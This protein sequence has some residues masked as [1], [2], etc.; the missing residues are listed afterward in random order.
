MTTF[1]PSHAYALIDSALF[2]DTDES[3]LGFGRRLEFVWRS[4]VIY[5]C[6]YE[7]AS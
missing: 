5:S 2:L 4:V 6:D 1:R 3:I 7:K